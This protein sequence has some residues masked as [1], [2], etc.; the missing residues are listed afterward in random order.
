MRTALVRGPADQCRRKPQRCAAQ[1]RRRRFLGFNDFGELG[2]GTYQSRSTPVRV[3]AV[4]Q[5]APC[6]QHLVLIRAISVGGS[7]TL[8]LQPDYS[9]ISWGLNNQGQLGDGTTETRPIPVR[10]RAPWP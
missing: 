4:G 1:Q 10:V 8:A 6:A 5:V 3:C 7:H 2:D 9:V